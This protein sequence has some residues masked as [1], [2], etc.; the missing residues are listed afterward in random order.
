MKLVRA[1]YVIPISEPIIVDGAMVV[2]GEK[3][4]AVGS[5]SDLIQ[6]YSNLP[7]DHHPHHVLLPGLVN[8]H[9][10]LDLTG[11]PRQA[12]DQRSSYSRWLLEQNRYKRQVPKEFL[13]DAAIQGI[14]ES[15]AAG[16]TCIGDMSS[17]GG[18]TALL[19]EKGL[20]AV[21]FPEIAS[22]DREGGQDLYEHALALV[23][24]NED[25]PSSLIRVGLGPYSPF[26]LSRQLLKI[27]AHY[28][29]GS[30]LLVQIHAAE[31]FHEMELFFDSKGDLAQNLFPSIGWG[32]SLPPPHLRTPV[33][34]LSGIDFLKSKPI[35]VGAVHVSS[36]DVDLI[37]TSESKIVHCPRSSAY[38]LEGITPLRQ[39]MTAGITVGLGTDSH[40][41][42]ETLSMW[43]DMRTCLLV[44]RST[45]APLTAPEV[46]TLATLGSARV[47]GLEEKIGSLAPGKAADYLVVEL[48]R[49]LPSP[50]ALIEHLLLHTYPHEVV[51]VAVGGVLLKNRV[52]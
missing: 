49:E 22:F 15:I 41:S 27:I 31:S 43:D 16:T 11:F 13:R 12:Y 44:H 17:L 25:H 32:E 37:A 10:H 33:Q 29:R 42:V 18:V 45:A 6:Q 26:T 23:E 24:A 46:L 48:G 50:D 14:E 8:A 7:I 19:E 34:Y 40:A 1:A 51:Q 20:R 52:D 9:A 30:A 47:L 3:I 5:A 36:G 2:D 21:V 35:L 4:V 39:C 28:A 38:F